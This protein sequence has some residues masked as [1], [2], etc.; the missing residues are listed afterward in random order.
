M[1]GTHWVRVLQECLELVVLCERDYLQYRAKLGENL[2][3]GVRGR[4]SHSSEK[5]RMKLLF[6]MTVSAT[7]PLNSKTYYTAVQSRDLYPPSSTQ[8]NFKIAKKALA[9]W[10]NSYCKQK[11]QW[12]NL[13]T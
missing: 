11:A 6:G 12:I 5:A 9:S 3:G 13:A 7:D 8:A 2:P 1:L 4:E 10:L